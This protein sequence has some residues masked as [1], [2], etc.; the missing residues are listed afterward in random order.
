VQDPPRGG[1]RVLYRTNLSAQCG[2][3]RIDSAETEH[4]V[5]LP[6]VSLDQTGLRAGHSA[7]FAAST[8]P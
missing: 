1:T 7:L 5:E 6:T 8:R 3:P 2:G 4:Q